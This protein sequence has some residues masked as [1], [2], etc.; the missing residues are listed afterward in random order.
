MTDT[1]RELALDERRDDSPSGSGLATVLGLR[2]NARDDPR[3]RVHEDDGG[4]DDPRGQFG[5]AGVLQHTQAPICEHRRVDKTRN[6]PKQ[7]HHS[8]RGHDSRRGNGED[9]AGERGPFIRPS[10]Y[11]GNDGGDSRA[12]SLLG[13]GALP[14]EADNVRANSVGKELWTIEKRGSASPQAYR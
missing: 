1:E 12:T 6:R 4:G 14:T 2:E 7:V 5:L 3:E 10:S 11:D 8:R 9:Y 13:E